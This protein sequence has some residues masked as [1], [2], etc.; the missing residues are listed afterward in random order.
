MS[1][2]GAAD[3]MTEP[4][5]GIA[6][7]KSV[8]QALVGR[9]TSTMTTRY[10]K[11]H[12]EDVASILTRAVEIMSACPQASCGCKVETPEI[13]K[14]FANLFAADSPPTCIDCGSQRGESD[15]EGECLNHLFADGFD[16]GL[17][18]AA[19]GLDDGR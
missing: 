10:Q 16:R 1:G 11:R 13:V 5:E 4:R 19:C 18:L 8:S 9:R 12:Y 17:F 2:I 6:Q 14:D 3:A 15:P 7:W